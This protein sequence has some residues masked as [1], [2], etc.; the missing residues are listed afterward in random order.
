MVLLQFE[1]LGQLAVDR[2]DDL[3]NA[4]NTLSN[5]SGELPALV[6]SGHSHQADAIAT[7]E[8]LS[9]R[10]A[11]VPLVRNGIQVGVLL[12][13]F[14]SA[15]HVCNVGR[16][17][18][19]VEDHS[20][21]RYEKLHLVSKEDLLLGRDSSE[22]GSISSPFSGGLRSQMELHHRYGQAIDAALAVSSY[23]QHSQHQVSDQ[24]ESVHEC[25]SASVETALT[26]NV[27]EQVTTLV[28]LRKQRQLS[29]PPLALSN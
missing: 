1:L 28:P 27:R 6:S 11:D 22:S 26:R 18:F 8:S 14:V 16:H 9:Y 13:Q 24:V 21:Q 2:L 15:L 19:E 25:S 10:S 17:K 12:Q 3:P 29:V 7:K 4:C 5:G 23:I 20:S